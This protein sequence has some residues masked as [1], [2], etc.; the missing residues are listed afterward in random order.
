MAGTVFGA[1]GSIHCEKIKTE[2]ESRPCA[3]TGSLLDIAFELPGVKSILG[4]S[5]EHLN[6][7]LPR[8]AGGPQV[9]PVPGSHSSGRLETP[10]RPE[11]RQLRAT[12]ACEAP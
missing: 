11:G 7:I 9:S 4:R 12:R 2:G 1:Q 8:L 10:P 6:P 3:P 5:S